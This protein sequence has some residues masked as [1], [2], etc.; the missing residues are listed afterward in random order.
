MSRRLRFGK[1]GKHIQERYLKDHVFH[2][3][4]KKVIISFEEMASHSVYYPRASV[5]HWH[6]AVE[7]EGGKSKSA[8]AGIDI[9]KERIFE[10]MVSCADNFKICSKYESYVVKEKLLLTS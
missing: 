1:P 10:K 5:G 8:T 2:F 9:S 4:P 6:W 7:V 3:N